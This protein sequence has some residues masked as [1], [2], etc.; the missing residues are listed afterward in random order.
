M[1]RNIFTKRKSREA[2]ANIAG[3]VLLISAS[4]AL[5]LAYFDVLT[6]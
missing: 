5:L 1:K 3:A 4:V 6:K 2:L